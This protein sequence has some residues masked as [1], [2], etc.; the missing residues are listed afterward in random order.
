MEKVEPKI[1][2]PGWSDDEI[3]EWMD[4]KVGAR[5]ALKTA[6]ECKGF[7]EQNVRQHEE[8]IAELTAKSALEVA[9]RDQD[10]IPHL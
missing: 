9:G 8:R 6:V 5:E 7:A 1:I 4:S 3:Y 10:P 2:A